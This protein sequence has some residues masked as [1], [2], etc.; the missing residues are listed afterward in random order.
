MPPKG[1]RAAGG[2]PQADGDAVEE[3]Y[4]VEDEFLQAMLDAGGGVGLESDDDADADSE[5]RQ[6]ILL[7]ASLR[8]T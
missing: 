1:K 7:W 4:D 8:P 6:G 5:S 2:L 3:E